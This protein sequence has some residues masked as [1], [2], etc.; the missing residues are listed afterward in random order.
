MPLPD[1]SRR[2]RTWPVLL[3]AGVPTIITAFLWANSPFEISGPQLLAAFILC[4]VP[5]A[6]YRE[7]EQGERKEIPIFPMIALMYWLAYGVPLFWMSHDISLVTGEFHLSSEAMTAA[8]YLGVVGIIAIWLGMKVARRWQW[9][10]YFNV[11]VSKKS[12]RWQYLRLAL[13]VGAG[14]RMFVPINAWGAGGRQFI[15]NVELIIPSVTFAILLRY[16]L[17]G[18]ALNPDKFLILT[19]GGVALVVGIASGWLGTFVN[20]GVMCVAVYVYEKRKL[21]M[22]AALVIIP[23]IFFLQ[24][25]KEEFRGRYWE[26][27]SGDSPIERVE[28]WL[29]TSAQMWGNAITDPNSEAVRKLADTTLKR[30]SLL[31]QTANVLEITPERVPYQDGKLYSYMLVT[32]IPRVLWPDKPSVNDANMW[33]QVSYR[34]TSSRGVSGVSIAV[35]SL[36][37]SYINF[38]WFGPIIVMFVIG[39]CLELFHRLFMRSEAGVLLNSIG[40]SLLP[41]LLAIESQLA[42]YLAGLVQ[43]V[44]VALFVLAP[45]LEFTRRRARKRMQPI[46][47]PAFAGAGILKHKIPVQSRQ[48]ATSISGSSST[49]VG[50]AQD[51]S[52]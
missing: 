3:Y 19:Y 40:V 51:V 30:F 28:F 5:W 24:P 6:S 38:G 14:L 12:S 23:V 21:P 8:M 33:Y 22:T 52:S 31:Q 18:R 44:A 41:G 36:A 42:Q 29:S 37:E 46:F 16:Y 1:K 17:R 47:S 43:Q 48:P 20:L 7:W 2:S 27:S 13:I 50:A 4:W 49:N 35:G 45:V 15:A 34:L 25:G 11:D 32:F 39:I 10:P 9:F 26:G